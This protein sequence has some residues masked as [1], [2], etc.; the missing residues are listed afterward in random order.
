M[1]R[2]GQEV[3]GKR[4]YL[5]RQTSKKPKLRPQKSSPG[6]SRERLGSARTSQVER[7]NAARAP[8][9]SRAY[10]FLPVERSQ[11]QRRGRNA[12]KRGASAAR[13]PSACMRIVEWKSISISISISI[14]VSVSASVSVSVYLFG[15]G[16]EWGFG[17]GSWARNRLPASPEWN[18]EHRNEDWGLVPSIPLGQM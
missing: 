12:A 2:E 11:S 6:A 1:F 13:A 9:D 5:K 7:K 17:S 16:Y 4:A 8:S 18:T 10:I 3:L 14:S 15:S